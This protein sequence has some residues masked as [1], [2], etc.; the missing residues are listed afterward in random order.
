MKKIAYL[1]GLLDSQGTIG[2]K[3]GK[4]AG[5]YTFGYVIEPYVN[6]TQGK[7]REEFVRKV[8]DLLGMGHI[9]RHTEKIRRT[10][11]H[12]HVTQKVQAWAT[13]RVTRESDLLTMVQAIKPHLIFKHRQAELMITILEKKRQGKH[14]SLKGFLECLDLAYDLRMQSTF[15]TRMTWTTKERF[16]RI[17][18][19]ATQNYQDW[20]SRT[21]HA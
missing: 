20:S 13:L 2:V 6:F 21:T 7:P 18:S 5:H 9:H 17:R 11:V 1:A 12:K 3:V 14:R 4:R 15:P 16:D 8:K 19:E 10:L